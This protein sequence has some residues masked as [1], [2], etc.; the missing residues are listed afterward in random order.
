MK[1]TRTFFCMI[2]ATL[3]SIAIGGAQPVISGVKGSANP[4][5]NQPSTLAANTGTNLPTSSSIDI[6]YNR[7]VTIDLSYG[8]TNASTSNTVTA[9]LAPSMDG[10]THSASSEFTIAKPSS[11][12]SNVETNLTYDTGA[13]PF[14]MV[15]SITNG[16]ATGIASVTNASG[17]LR[18]STKPGF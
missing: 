16:G 17:F 14:L 12:T 9:T 4:V 18:Y 3:L 11:G 1:F 15:L 2:C 7:L 5:A 10:V 8:C 6:G 13:F